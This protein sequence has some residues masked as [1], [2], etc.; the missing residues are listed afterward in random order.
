MPPG[1]RP[2]RRRGDPASPG[3]SETSDPARIRL[4]VR[5]LPGTG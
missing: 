2:R 1:D 3:R 5:D 4:S